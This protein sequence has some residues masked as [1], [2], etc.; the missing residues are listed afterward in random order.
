MNAKTSITLSEDVLDSVDRVAGSK[1]SRCAF[2]ERILRK[3][4]RDHANP[5]LQERDLK[6]INRAADRLNRE[7]AEILGY[8]KSGE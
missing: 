6:R 1:E 7:A 4:L 3:Y 5:A 2:I 8:Q